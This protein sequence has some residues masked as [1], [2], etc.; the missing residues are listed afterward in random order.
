[1]AD[2]SVSSPA[3]H[4]FV[5]MGLLGRFRDLPGGRSLLLNTLDDAH[6]YGLTH[7]T[8]CKATWEMKII[9]KTELSYD[10]KSRV[11]NLCEAKNQETP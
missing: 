1:M 9:R 2:P 5:L 7:V 11:F 4:S 10:Y 8:H 6:C 3:Q